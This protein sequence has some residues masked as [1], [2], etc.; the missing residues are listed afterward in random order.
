MT[1]EMASWSAD[2]MGQP[3]FNP[4]RLTLAR[5]RNGL[6]KQGLA[7][8]CG[9]SRRTVTAWEAGEVDAPP[10]ENIAQVL[11]FPTSFFCADDPLLIAREGVSFR[12]LSSMTARQVSRVLAASALAAELSSWMDERYS[13]PGLDLPDLSESQDNSASEHPENQ[14]GLLPAVVAE[15]ARSIWSIHQQPV[16]ALLPFLEKKGVRI[17]SLPVAD[18]EVDAFSFWQE[19]RPF[20]LLNTGKTAERIRFD[21]AHELGHLLMHRGINTQRNRA[22]E[23]QAQDFASSFLI[24]A[25][26]LYAQVIGQLRLEDVFQLKRYWKV[27]AVAMVHRLWELSIIS[28]WHYRTWMIDLSQRGYRSAEPDGIHPE[29]SRLFKQ[30]F[31]LTREDG[32]SSRRIASELSIP[33]DEL[34]SM[35]FGLA[36][37]PAPSNVTSTGASVPRYGLRLV[38]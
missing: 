18:R 7:T 10:I 35:V 12:A 3:S 30:L 23:Q 15:S 24:P 1:A 34:D 27:S 31:Q 25:D 2:S 19:D 11:N 9:V 36:I 33:E 29:S 4:G 38:E 14:E 22:F 20:I 17:F 28:E 13:T 37:A 32:W 6:T 5:E 16:K 8:L 26:A 21:L